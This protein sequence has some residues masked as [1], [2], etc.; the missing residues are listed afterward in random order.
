MSNTFHFLIADD[1]LGDRK[2]IRTSLTSSGLCFESTEVST[3]EEALDA[4]EK[5]SFDC[6]ILDYRL[7]GKDGLTGISLM[8]DKYPYMPIVMSTGKGDERIAAEAIKRGAEEYISKDHIDAKTLRHISENAVKRAA[9]KRRVTEQQLEL[10]Q[11]A[12]ILA[13][14]LKAPLRV[15]TKFGE[16]LE[17][18]LTTTVD[19][20]EA[21]RLSGRMSLAA[22]RVTK[23]I[24]ILHGYTHLRKPILLA[25]VQLREAFQ[26]AL[27]NLQPLVQQSNVAFKCEFLPEVSGNKEQLSQVFQNLIENSIKFSTTT[28]PHIRIWSEQQSDHMWCINVED[29][30]IG[31][32]K[33]YYKTV[34]EPF[35]KLH[36]QDDFEGSGLGLA[37]C[38][39]IVERHGGIITCDAA[40]NGGTV[41]RFTLRPA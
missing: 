4:C 38:R 17:E 29:N 5:V 41:I 33:G 22:A 35:K 39:K 24:D 21:L 32:P 23:L 1:D 11:F 3:I 6:A 9:L 40:K 15:I 37:I 30:G 31:I 2:L 20:E 28:E 13:H 25:P 7:P 12:H 18:E 16:L 8:R 26:E 27:D 34:F 19:I 14:D 36:T 10:E